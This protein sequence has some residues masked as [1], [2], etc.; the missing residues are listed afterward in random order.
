MQQSDVYYQLL[1]QH[2]ETEV[3]NKHLM[4]ILLVFSLTSQLA[5]YRSN[6]H[7]RIINS[8]YGLISTTVFKHGVMKGQEELWNGSK[9]IVI[10]I[11][12]R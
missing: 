4:L 9:I 5:T 3:D 11:R 12:W 1:S 8:G 2:V 6:F 10:S 7:V